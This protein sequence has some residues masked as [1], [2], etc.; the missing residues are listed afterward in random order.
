M[1]RRFF[2]LAIALLMATCTS[3]FL[4]WPTGLNMEEWQPP[5]AT[6]WPTNQAL[7]PETILHPELSGPETMV[8]D[9]QGRI[10]TG[11]TDGRI[12][13]FAASQTGP[14]ETLVNTGGRPLGLAYDA[15]GNLIV[16]DADR[17]LLA[18][19]PSGHI[20]VLTTGHDG[21][22]FRFTDDVAIAQNGLIYFTDA[23]DRFSIADYKLEILE[24][25]PRGRV[26]VFEPKTRTTALIAD[27]LYFPNGIALGPDDAYL[28]V[29][30]TSSYRLRRIWLAG[31]QRGESETMVANLPGFLDNVRFSPARGVFW[32]AIGSPRNTM[33]DWLAPHPFLRQIVVRLP[34]FLQPAPER[35]SFALAYDEH[36]KLVHDLQ[37]VGN[38]AYAPVAT[39]LEHRGRLYLGSFAA[40]GIATVPAPPR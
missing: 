35:H 40:A 24:H 5:E 18:V 31:E 13:R 30:E 26:L 22:P 29:A 8:I 28:V 34:S 12:V 37:C 7:L 25:Q 21:R 39:V 33:V 11:L 19:S 17:G 23:S 9:P 2:L 27:K 4:A 38:D 3:Y 15:S 20:D 32:V 10:V 36:G 6:D 1:S 14:V 16:A